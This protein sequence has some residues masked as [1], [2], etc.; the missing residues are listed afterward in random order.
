MTSAIIVGVAIALVVVSMLHRGSGSRTLLL[1]CIAMAILASALLRELEDVYGGPPPMD[2]L[3]RLI[4]LI[5]QAAVVALVLTFR[6]P[7]ASRHVFR[8][9]WAVAAAVGLVECALFLIMPTRVEPTL[10]AHAATSVAAFLYYALYETTIAVTAA[11]CA[12]GSIMVLL[13]TRQPLVARLSLLSLMLAAAVAMIYVGVGWFSLTQTPGIGSLVLRRRLFLVA[14]SL[15]LAGMTASGIHGILLGVR[16]AVTM[17]VAI[18][19][20]EPLWRGVIRLHPGVMLPVDRPTRRER[21]L[22]LV[23]ETNDAL[24]RISLGAGRPPGAADAAAT[25]QLLADLLGES[26]LPGPLSRRTRLLVGCGALEADDALLSA[27]RDLY[28]VRVA[29]TARDQGRGRSLSAVAPL[30]PEAVGWIRMAR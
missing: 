29:L 7:A 21:L 8:W 2:L 6:R 24:H 18:D 11:F 22:R 10:Y 4:F 5:A 23:V 30:A 16:A 14:I 1:R 28:D 9:V 12:L 17:C 26:A 27:I 15:L 25:A 13:R 19:V 3:K 20:V